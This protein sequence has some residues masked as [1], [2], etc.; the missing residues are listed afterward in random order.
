MRGFRP[1]EGWVLPQWR[2]KHR[3]LRRPSFAKPPAGPQRPGTRSLPPPP[4][5]TGPGRPRRRVPSPLPGPGAASRGLCRAGAAAL[6]PSVSP[7]PPLPTAEPGARRRARPPLPAPPRR[8]AP[9]GEVA[10]ARP[11]SRTA[12]PG[13][14]GRFAEAVAGE[15]PGPG[16]ASQVGECGPPGGEG[17][18]GWVMSPPR[19]GGGG[20][21]ARRGGGAR[22]G[23]ADWQRGPARS[24]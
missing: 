13:A 12:R 14:V 4:A 3:A 18:A 24:P 11:A 5:G 9:W 22:P 6:V 21:R 19:S 8:S 7:P 15:G 23:A 1:R 10:A 20:G 16:M 2:Q 17:A